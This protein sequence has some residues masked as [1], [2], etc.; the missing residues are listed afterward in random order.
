MM[1][2]LN[3]LLADT[4]KVGFYALGLVA[5]IASLRVVMHANPIHAILSLIVSLLSVAGIFFVI[6]APF[7]GV[8]EVIVYAGAILVLFVFVIMMLN[9]GHD[10]DVQ[11][12][13]WLSAQV[14]AIPTALM[15][16]IGVVMVAMLR[17]G[18]GK[19][20]AMM[21]RQTV[22]AKAVGISLFTEYVFLV[23]I[24]S[25]L[26]LSALVAAYHLGKRALDDENISHYSEKEGSEK[27]DGDHD[28]GALK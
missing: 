16:I 25:F 13:S 19:E 28:K 24:A 2:W 21:G 5:I 20:L 12:R 22:S 8:L 6:G 10:N 7:A 17:L 23:E 4:A 11:E 14:W 26:L 3:A 15:V 18:G 9:L 1:D 27:A